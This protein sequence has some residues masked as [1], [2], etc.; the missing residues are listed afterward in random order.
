MKLGNPWTFGIL[1]M[2]AFC[3]FAWNNFELPKVFWT[4]T[5]ETKAIVIDYKSVPTHR[6][7]H[8]QL[9]IFAYQ[10]QDSMYIGRHTVNHRKFQDRS[11]GSKL[12]IEYAVNNPS[13]FKVLNYYQFHDYS[14]PARY[15]WQE[16]F[17]E[18]DELYME[19]GIVK[20]DHKTN[21][22]KLK[23]SFLGQSKKVDGATWVVP[24]FESFKPE[25]M[26][27]Y[28]VQTEDHRNDTLLDSVSQKKYWRIKKPQ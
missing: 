11:I 8:S 13:N 12:E 1:F 2:C 3:Y 15:L 16:N 7:Y 6:Y 18:Y 24:M 26:A 23:S 14:W 9:I 19:N 21:G 17:G 28:L 27:M 25:N 5:A 10:V 4:E 20:L 22:G